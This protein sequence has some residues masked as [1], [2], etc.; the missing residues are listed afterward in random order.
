MQHKSLANGAWA[1]LSFIEQ[2][3][4]I[5]SEVERSIKWKDK[6]QDKFFQK[7]FERLM[8]LLDLTI[9]LNIKNKGKLKELLRVKECL[10]DSL[11][12]ENKYQSSDVAW[13]KYFR[14]FNLAVRN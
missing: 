6:G 12:F 2:M 9:N 10:N 7:A 1:K 11:V 5:G 3:T 13:R 4:N 8:E 14:A